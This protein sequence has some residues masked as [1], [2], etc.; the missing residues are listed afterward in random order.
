MESSKGIGCDSKGIIYILENPIYDQTGIVKIGYTTDLEKRLK[1][2]NA[3][4]GVAKAFRPYATYEV[5][6]KLEDKT[7]FRLIEGI[8]PD[9]RVSEKY[10]GK[11]RE[12]EFFKMTKEEAYRL[13]ECIAEISGTGNRL[14]KVQRD[15]ELKEEEREVA[16]AAEAVRLGAF[17]FS[18]CGIKPGEILNFVRDPSK[19][20]E[21]V[22]DK[23]VRY[24]DYTTSLSR[25][26]K[27]L[28]GSKYAVQGPKYFTY[29][30][31]LLTELRGEKC[32][33]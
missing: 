21:V 33:K 13:L 27:D 15:K 7:L 22:D 10:H 1:S 26:A 4:T 3:Q 16:E 17:R 9:L 2:L 29:K 25:L 12:R 23:R 30:G 20:A 32:C 14:K 18:L 8:N 19:T 5:K 11:R 24:D 31:K 28:L 6:R